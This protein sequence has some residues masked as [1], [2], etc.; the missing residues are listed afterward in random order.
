MQQTA[1]Y[2]GRVLCCAEYI[3]KRR[4]KGF[5]SQAPPRHQNKPDVNPFIRLSNKTVNLRHRF[6]HKK[7]P[8]QNK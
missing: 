4:K 5:V 2:F 6:K 1:T 7:N 3:Y 8:E